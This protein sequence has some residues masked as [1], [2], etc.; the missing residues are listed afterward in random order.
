MVMAVMKTAAQEKDVKQLLD[1]VPLMNAWT[2]VA[3]HEMAYF[4][5]VTFPFKHILAALAGLSASKAQAD[6][7]AKIYKVSCLV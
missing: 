5:Y 6:H 2:A 1:L 3:R 4:A 7:L